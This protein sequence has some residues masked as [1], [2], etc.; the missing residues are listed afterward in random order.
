MNGSDGS[1]PTGIFNDTNIALKEV[2]AVPPGQGQIELLPDRTVGLQQ[3]LQ[4]YGHNGAY[5]SEGKPRKMLE[6]PKLREL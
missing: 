3:G 6:A 5:N 4:G 1:R 2:L